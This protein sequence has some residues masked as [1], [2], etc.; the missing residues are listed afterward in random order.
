MNKNIVLQVLDEVMY[1][2]ANRNTSKLATKYGPAVISQVCEDNTM[3]GLK[4]KYHLNQ[5]EMVNISVPS[6]KKVCHFSVCIQLNMSKNHI[7]HYCMYNKGFAV[8]RKAFS[9]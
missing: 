1:S 3:S 6:S 5:L 7:M 8:Y 4:R 2:I 9:N